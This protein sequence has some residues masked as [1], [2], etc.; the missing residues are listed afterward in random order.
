MAAPKKRRGDRRRPSHQAV[1]VAV[2]SL[3]RGYTQEQLRLAAKRARGHVRHVPAL[4]TRDRRRSPGAVAAAQVSEAAKAVVA[5]EVD[6]STGLVVEVVECLVIEATPE[7]QFE[8]RRLRAANLAD[9]RPTFP[10]EMERLMIERAKYVTPLEPRT[11]HPGSPYDSLQPRRPAARPAPFV[12]FAETPIQLYFAKSPASTRERVIRWHRAAR[13]A[14]AWAEFLGT[15]TWHTLVLAAR[16]L[17]QNVGFWVDFFYPDPATMP[18][19]API[20]TTYREHV[21]RARALIH[22]R[23][24]VEPLEA[25]GL[26]RAAYW[27][28]RREEVPARSTFYPVVRGA[29]KLRA[30]EIAAGWRVDRSTSASA[31]GRHRPLALREFRY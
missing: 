14:R 11:P 17:V 8:P 1:A 16:W 24:S 23:W 5:I 25:W 6:P 15:L 7:P 20:P 28:M 9:F 10:D 31:V 2:A 30:R 13:D 19:R 4:L 21:A 29:R 3:Q 18:P 26:S 22:K 27:F 12:P